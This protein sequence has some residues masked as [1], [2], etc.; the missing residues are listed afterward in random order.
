MSKALITLI[1][2][3]F[4]VV[5]SAKAQTP[6]PSDP[7]SAPL[8]S[9]F[10]LDRENIH[11]HLNKERYITNEIIWI[12]GYVIDKK[13]SKPFT[14]TANIHVNLLDSDG[15]IILTNLLYAEN[16][17]FVGYITLNESLPSGK[18]R[19]QAYTGYM[20]NFSEDE[21]TVVP[22]VI[23]NQNDKSITDYNVAN[24]S[25]LTI[26]MFPESG[27]FIEGINNSV[28]ISVTD[29]N[30]N[31][32]AITQG[33]VLS[34]AGDVVSNFSTN[35][36]GYGKFEIL[37]TKSGIYKVLFEIEGRKFEENLTAAQ[38]SGIAFTAN[39]Y[40]LA[41]KMILHLKTNDITLKTIANQKYTFVIHQNDVVALADYTFKAG[42]KEALI[43]IASQ[44]LSEG[45]NTIRLINSSNQQIAERNVFKPFTITSNTMIS[46]QQSIVDSV[47]FKG[48]S[49]VAFANLSISVLPAETIA[50]SHS[51]INGALHL[52]NYLKQPIKN[53]HYY[54]ENFNRK[55]HFELDNVLIT[56]AS[57]YDWNSML[58]NPPQEK[59]P[60]DSGLTI[61][62]TVNSDVANRD[63]VSIL[64]SSPLL[65]INETTKL[66]SK[67]EFEFKNVMA[68]D[69][70]TLYFS[71]IDEK[72]RF[73]KLNM[74]T[75]IANPRTN[76]IRSTVSKVN[77]CTT[78]NV[79]ITN[80]TYPETR[81]A[82]L[83]N[84]VNVDAINTKEE[85]SKKYE[86]RFNNNMARGYKIT[87][88][89]ASSFYDVLQWI[90][91]RGFVTNVQGGKVTIT[92]NYIRSFTGTSSP[93]VFIDDAPLID[94]DLLANMRMSTI[95]EIY[96]NR[97]GY[98]T[99]SSTGG[100]G[101]IRIYTKKGLSS[102][103]SSIKINSQSLAVT[104]AY[105][106]M[107][108]FKNPEY[109]SVS[110]TSFKQFG[111]IA[112]LNNVDTDENGMFT[113]AI[114]NLY[115]PNVLVQIEGISA[116]G[117]MVSEQMLVTVPQK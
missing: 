101:V 95:D 5:N 103:G 85:L 15:K 14:A 104:N 44:Y 33:Q 20:N 66:N 48:K 79:V 51:N 50:K 21:S 111:T 35:A 96:I 115:Q 75:R 18:Y 70:T 97:N 39:N 2:S 38:T 62:G 61:K 100:N 4:V 107:K 60:F 58:Q 84:A 9:Y 72:G 116:D 26:A 113:F 56:S 27:V 3:F 10:K 108:N 40:A 91:N 53:S 43:P 83:L 105:Q 86:Y 55:K 42:E 36:N 29:C 49:P 78:G 12:K 73:T 59:F 106:A 45:I 64:M 88:S 34:P 109:Q 47:L 24:L 57:K 114:P 80:V 25:S 7:F 90:G 68:I 1:C 94:Y 31:G 102:N 67:N 54:F 37:D 77:I 74:Y 52:N 87:E 81:D 110:D 30:D 92:T 17:L 11:L 71:L 89:E 112:W 65:G 6:I 76:F 117:T 69:S 98:G 16:S 93:A 23:N 63:K 8:K 99:G 46:V 22:I 19:L 28:A 13:N 82:I 32:V 41:D